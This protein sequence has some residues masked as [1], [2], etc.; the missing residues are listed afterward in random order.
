M[1]VRHQKGC[2]F[3]SILL[4]VFQIF[5]FQIALLAFQQQDGFASDGNLLAL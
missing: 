1:T 4:V 2:L 3:K 5:F